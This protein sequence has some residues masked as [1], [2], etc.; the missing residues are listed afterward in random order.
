MYL[1]QQLNNFVSKLDILHTLHYTQRNRCGADVEGVW[2]GEG[3][4]RCKSMNLKFEELM[5]IKYNI[6]RN[7]NLRLIK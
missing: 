7:A 1:S 3:R 2:N 6:R 4:V 5:C